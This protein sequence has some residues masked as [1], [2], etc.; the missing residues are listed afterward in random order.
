MAVCC[1]TH[2]FAIIVVCS[3]AG[4]A[5]ILFIRLGGWTECWTGEDGVHN[6]GHKITKALNYK[7]RPF[8]NQPAQ[9]D[10][11]CYC[12]STLFSATIQYSLLRNITTVQWTCQH[13]KYYNS[14]VN[15]STHKYYKSPVNL[16]THKY[17]NS[18]VNL[19]T[20]KYYNCPMNMS[21][22]KLYPTLYL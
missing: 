14:P 19:S 6:L 10:C 17:Y 15:L 1:A 11:K 3:S 2:L 5:Y 12:V 13:I 20:H 4:A 9:F 16:S 8:Q 18:P 7:I 22:H 21:T